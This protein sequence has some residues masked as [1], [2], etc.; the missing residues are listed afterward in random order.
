MKKTQQQPISWPAL[1]ALLSML[2][3]LAPGAQAAPLLQV[4]PAA[5]ALTGS[6]GAAPAEL[7]QSEWASVGEQ[8]RQAAY[9]VEWDPTAAAYRA[10]NSE[11]GFTA[12]FTDA[13]VQLD[14]LSG[15]E[16]GWRVHLAFA[17]LSR[18]PAPS[19]L[20]AHG[21]ESAADV[22][23][24]ASTSR[25]EPVSESAAS[26]TPGASRW[27][28]RLQL[29]HTL[30]L[31]SSNTLALVREWY[32]NTAAGLEH[33]FT[34][35]APIG[36]RTDGAL[37]LEIAVDTDLQ[38]ALSP[39]GAAD[40]FAAIFRSASGEQALS[41]EALKAYD[42]A[43]D[44][45]PA[46][47]QLD[48][49]AEAS[50]SCAIQ[51]VID[52]RTA[53]YPLTI[54]PL[55][56]T[57]KTRLTAP[58]GI[59][60]EGF[61]K[62]ALGQNLL[63]VGVPLNDV[64]AAAD[65]GSVYLFT[66]G[67][68]SAEG[69]SFLRQ[70]TAPDGAAGDRFGES[71]A[72]GD[73]V[74][75]VGAPGKAAERGA[76]YLF[77]RHLGGADN[78]GQHH[79]FI[80][81][82]SLVGDQYGFSVALSGA[83]AA[84]GAPQA[85]AAA[86]SAY[87]YGRDQGG[88]DQWGQVRRLSASDAS[89]GDRFGYAVSLSGKWLLAGAPF[90][91][92]GPNTDQGSAYV[93]QQDHFGTNVW[94][95]LRHIN[96][97]DGRPNDH[98]GH[99][100]AISGDALVIGAPQADGGAIDSG[101]AYIHQ[102]DQGGMDGWGFQRKLY[103][104][105]NATGDRYGEAVTLYAAWLAVGAPGDDT[106]PDIDQGSI[107]YYH[108]HYT[109]SNAWGRVS[110]LYAGDAQGGDSFGASVAVYQ[111]VLAVAATGDDLGANLDQGSVLVY[112]RG[113]GDWVQSLALNVPDGAAGDLFGLS[114]S[115][116][117][118]LLAVGAPGAL[119][120]SNDNQG[121][122][123]I[124]SRSGFGAENWGM[125]KKIVALDGAA[126]D[127]FGYAVS[128]H[129]EW[130]IVGAPSADD[131]FANQGKAYIF[132]RNQG[133]EDNWGYVRTITALD[134]AA[135]DQ[136][137]YTVAIS[138]D[139]AAAGAPQADPA[140][141]GAVYLFSRNLGGADNWGQEAK[142]TG[143]DSVSGDRFGFS[144][145]LDGDSL[146]AGAPRHQAGRGAA[147]LFQRNQGGQNN[148]G[149][150]KKRMTSSPF[151]DDEFG[152]SIALDD[153]TLA[154]GAP[155]VDLADGA[156][157]GAAFVYQRGLGGADAWGLM[158]KVLH[159]APLSADAFGWSISLDGD[160]LAIGA[161]LRTIAGLAGR[162][163]VVLYG[164]NQAGA[165]KWG[166][167][168]RLPA[169]GTEINDYFGWSVS[170]SG[171]YLASGASADDLD[172][173]TDQGAVYVFAWQPTD[174]VLETH[175]L[176]PGGLSYNGFGYSVALSGSTLAVG[177]PWADVWAIDQGRVY[178]FE[179]D[180]GGVNGWGLL[181]SLTA[182]DGAAYDYLGWSLAMSGDLLIA[183]AP[184]DDSPTINDRGAAYVYERHRGGPDAWGQAH[185]LVA[186]DS[187]KDAFL[188][189]SVGIS[190]DTA[191]A[192]A[193]GKAGAGGLEQGAAYIFTRNQGGANAW[194]Q[195]R[196]LFDPLGKAGDRLGWST[197]ISGGSALTGAP[198]ADQATLLD[199]GTVVAFERNQGG[200]DAWGSVVRLWAN[201]AHAGDRFGTTLAMDGSTFIAGAPTANVGA[202]AEQGAAYIFGRI[203]GNINSTD[204][205][206]WGQVRKLTAPEGLAYDHFG[207]SVGISGDR[208]IVGAF[209]DQVIVNPR[210]GSAHIF[211]RNYSG[212]DSWGRVLYLQAV[213]GLSDEYYGTAVA[214]SGELAAVG[215]YDRQSLTN[216]Q[217]SAYVY[218]LMHLK[219]LFMP[220]IDS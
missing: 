119:V 41:Y 204:Q 203:L 202:N 18:S 83:W 120:G 66:R 130:L 180:L 101:A 69:W 49:C 174:W 22:Q 56:N 111:D 131:T 79:K 161:P 92:F 1:L 48:G 209:A 150:Q 181:T 175:P 196:K 3:S 19:G 164:R 133:G 104:L 40:G 57:Q 146:A 71:L 70:V 216:F 73:D 76:A 117:Q 195:V 33:G 179:Q 122:V 219:R 30:S 173:D 135:D 162:G 80:A 145:D 139:T 197:A 125:V 206:D 5:P 75:L 34:I 55:L 84:I 4:K 171:D 212:T 13:G 99:A 44:A 126:D 54:D 36:E 68:N 112:G 142:V 102:Q 35:P 217:G 77:R 67:P 160:R 168:K 136:L 39:D 165:G 15:G 24:L 127:I 61:G 141:Q 28:S 151:P 64:G 143:A 210:Q 52:D 7:T 6:T 103:E 213:D 72:L 129:Q 10:S 220:F 58:D 105:D 26:R 198:G 156:D 100:V 155:L 147:Y 96:A 200:A 110:K 199:L 194:G 187:A 184:Y 50:L 207:R 90:D 97:S 154:V 32:L 14:P 172:G 78:W 218:R 89:A 152:Y 208:A 42:A 98:Y 107:Y 185:K 21:L 45:V 169:G 60:G 115:L 95:E 20:A 211:E 121:A 201:D 88:I 114:V 124:F 128:L 193:P 214:I 86:G 91:D 188:G 144:V 29:K 93:F 132:F 138:Y 153:D 59:A 12:R 118:D 108:R 149:Q 178:L 38:V 191:I 177:A 17:G 190:G 116:H 182:S 158:K 148:W 2:L 113:L 134:A 63:A 215:A 81:A 65:Q 85:L 140:D 16:A 170:L 106:A 157:Q 94:G 31:R 27:T 123:Y 82:D 137:G 186:V 87:L 176:D 25:W 8:I 74:L 53:E 37:V 62:V 43:G 205:A 46:W 189:Y 166:L 159:P 167:L 11:N 192:G 163:E 183:G 47:M 51:L 9:A 23:P 109:G